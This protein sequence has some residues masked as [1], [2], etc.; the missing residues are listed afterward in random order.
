MEG[1]AITPDGKTLVG[2]MQAALIQD[3]GKTV[4][5]VTID[6]R[7][8]AT[9]QYAYT[10]TTGSGVSEILAINNHEFLVDERDGKGLGDNSTAAV[11]QL[12]HIDLNGAQEVMSTDTA[13]TVAGNAVVKTL[14]L[15]IVAVSRRMDDSKDIPKIEG[16]LTRHR[17]QR[18]DETPLRANDNDFIATVTDTNHPTG[19]D[20]PNKFSCLR[21]TPLTRRTLF[22]SK[23]PRSKSAAALMAASAEYWIQTECFI[24]KD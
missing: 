7:T 22:P 1:L 9:H 17:Y 21:L 24:A 3:G 6:I 10:L 5:I 8:G 16:L 15:D 13:A 18:R 20:N 11:K 2:I 4:R 23:S 12:Y 19:I 14:F